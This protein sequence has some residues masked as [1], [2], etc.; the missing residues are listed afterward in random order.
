[1][2]EQGAIVAAVAALSALAA[3]CAT[4]VIVSPAWSDVPTAEQLGDAYPE[5]AADMEIEGRAGLRCFVDPHGVLSECR[6]T[7]ATPAGL[8]F[9]RAAMALTP[10]FRASP[11]TV[12]GVRHRSEVQFGIQFRLAPRDERPAPW[13]GPAPAPEALAIAR[14]LV[15]TLPAPPAPDPAVLDVDPDRRGWLIAAI[16][17][18]NAELEPERREAVAL[19][20][21]RYLDLDTL[22]MLANGQRRPPP[23]TDPVRFASAHDRLAAVTEQRAARLRE[24]WC[25]RYGCGAYAAGAD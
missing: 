7:E 13:A 5:A 19:G 20:M 25:D 4:P 8:G 22:R 11:R 3:G 10:R 12:D 2:A 24:A 16:R 18:I 21:A 1:M 15:R 23:P 6:V 17:R 14:R 9:D